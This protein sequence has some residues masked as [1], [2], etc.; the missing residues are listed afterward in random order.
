MYSE[1]E[2]PCLIGDCKFATKTTLLLRRHRVAVHGLMALQR[3]EVHCCESTGYSKALNALCSGYPFCRAEEA[4]SLALAFVGA[5][6][7]RERAQSLLRIAPRR[8]RGAPVLRNVDDDARRAEL[9]LR[10]QVLVDEWAAL[11]RRATRSQS[12]PWKSSQE[13]YTRRTVDQ[14]VRIAALHDTPRPRAPRQPL[15]ADRFDKAAALYAESDAV[16]F[17]IN[18]SQGVCAMC[19]I[20]RDP[21]ALLRCGEPLPPAFRDE[22]EAA[23]RAE[24]AEKRK[25]HGE[26]R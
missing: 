26:L 11:P 2:M 19:G 6:T 8:A 10:K 14:L 9:E 20:N 12:K 7:A 22:Q 16:L 23:E 3:C 25:K 1:T 21:E 13:L 24:A 17:A 5:L 18:T 15:A 4:A